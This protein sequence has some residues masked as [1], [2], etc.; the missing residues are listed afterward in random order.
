MH[1]IETLLGG[2]A[3]I[4]FGIWSYHMTIG[5]EWLLFSI[6]TFATPPIGL[7]AVIYGLLQKDEKSEE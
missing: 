3:L 4:L 1:K 7:A 6:L 2:I 5:T